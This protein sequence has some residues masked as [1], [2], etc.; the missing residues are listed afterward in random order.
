MGLR[1]RVDA[2]LDFSAYR[3]LES[4]LAERKERRE[5]GLALIKSGSKLLEE[6]EGGDA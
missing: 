3:K 6:E 1:M 2:D 4:I 5:S